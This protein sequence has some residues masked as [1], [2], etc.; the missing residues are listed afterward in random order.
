M[1]AS[2]GWYQPRHLPHRD[3]AGLVQAITFHLKGS[4]PPRSPQA[5]LPNTR[6]EASAR[7]GM[8]RA[9]DQGWGECLLADPRAAQI[10]EEALFFGDNLRYL[11]LAWVVM[12]N[13]VHV[14]IET[15][16]GWGMDR[17]VGSWK[18]YTAGRINTL[19]GRNGPLWERDYYD[20][21]VRDEGHLG[22]AIRYVHNNPVK[23][24]LVESP[25]QWRYGSA[26]RVEDLSAPYHAPYTA[27]DL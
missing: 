7:E 14:L 26:W 25:E 13:H 24:G 20:R 10:V 1:G 15:R 5:D 23:A 8:H 22:S 19:L 18:T 27:T 9:L 11:L 16:A 21:F 6:R 4:R 17:V 12:P 3:E 2:R